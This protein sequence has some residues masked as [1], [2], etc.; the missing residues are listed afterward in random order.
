MHFIVNTQHIVY[1][2]FDTSSENTRHWIKVYDSEYTLWQKNIKSWA[3]VA[4]CFLLV[5][6]RIKA[7]RHKSIS[8]GTL[9][10]LSDSW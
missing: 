3:A 7:L 9:R 1:I 6:R 10:F 5:Y 8:S 2:Y 4:K